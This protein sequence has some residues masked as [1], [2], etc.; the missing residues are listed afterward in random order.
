[1][2][3]KSVFVFIQCRGSLYGYSNSFPKLVY[4]LSSNFSRTK[5]IADL[6][7]DGVRG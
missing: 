4:I 7:N 1:L 3:S 2:S 5:I 6:F